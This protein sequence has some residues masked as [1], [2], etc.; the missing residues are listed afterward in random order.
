[1]LNIYVQSRGDGNTG[2]QAFLE[3][4]AKG[5]IRIWNGKK[6]MSITK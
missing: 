4:Y 6:N 1:M 5:L 3:A 2:K